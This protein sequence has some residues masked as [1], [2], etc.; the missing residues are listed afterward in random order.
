[1]DDSVAN[2]TDGRS[3][4]QTMN[5]AVVG[6]GYVGLAVGECLADT[7]NDVCCVDLDEGKIARLQNGIVR[8]YEPGHEEIVRRNGALG[9][10]QFSTNLD[11]AI[12]SASVVFIAAGTPPDEGGSADL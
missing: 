8:I 1:M 10:L 7:G 11:G 12:R 5:V 9:R 2:S 4:D 6:V 3:G